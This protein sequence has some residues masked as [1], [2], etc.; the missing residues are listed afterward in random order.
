M[1]GYDNAA[2]SNLVLKP[3]V[4]MI[5]ELVLSLESCSHPFAGILHVALL[6]H[7]KE[8]KVQYK[9]LRKT[10]GCGLIRTQERVFIFHPSQPKVRCLEII[11][12][13]NFLKPNKTRVFVR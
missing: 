2:Y 6:K 3:N 8:T 9:C 12:S 11:T 4:F 13:F 5:K 7:I 10:C 1:E